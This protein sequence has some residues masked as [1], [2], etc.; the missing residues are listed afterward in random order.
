MIVALIFIV[1]GLIMI[2]FGFRLESYLQDECSYI[3]N[4]TNSTSKLMDFDDV[5]NITNTLLCNTTCPC[6]ASNFFF[7]SD[8]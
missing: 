7:F 8:L 1:F 6:A 5:Y 2:V 3:Y 4:S